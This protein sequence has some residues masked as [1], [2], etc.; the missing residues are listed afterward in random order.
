[1]RNASIVCSVVAAL[2]AS[3][4]NNATDVVCPAD[5]AQVKVSPTSR[6]M[7]MGEQFTPTVTAVICGG[8]QPTPFVGRF[9]TSNAAVARVDSIGGVI[10]GIASGETYVFA[11]YTTGGSPAGG[12][13]DSIRVTVR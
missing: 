8:S 1:M 11:R 7:N 2:V 12:T 3:G 6:T 5:P 4:C 10:T 9:S 13:R